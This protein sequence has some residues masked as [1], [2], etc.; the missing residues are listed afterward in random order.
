MTTLAS[1]LLAPALLDGD[2][3]A[4][5]RRLDVDIAAIA[6]AAPDDAAVDRIER[7]RRCVVATY[8]SALAHAAGRPDDPHWREFIASVSALLTHVPAI[9][10]S[11]PAERAIAR[12]R[13]LVDESPE[14]S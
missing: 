8:R 9:R 2:Q 10:Y 12:L 4:S 11:Y 3:R 6:L 13:A 14:I 5:V 1:F 7:L